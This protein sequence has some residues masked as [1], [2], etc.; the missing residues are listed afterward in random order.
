MTD[1][2][3]AFCGFVFASRF[4]YPLSC[5][6]KRRTMRL[7]ESR[8][9]SG[10]LRDRKVCATWSTAVLTDPSASLWMW[11][12]EYVA[13]RTACAKAQMM[14]VLWD[15]SGM[16]VRNWSSGRSI[17]CKNLIH[18]FQLRCRSSFVACV[19]PSAL[20]FSLAASRSTSLL[21]AEWEQCGSVEAA[22]G[23]FCEIQGRLVRGV[24]D[25]DHARGCLPVRCPSRETTGSKGMLCV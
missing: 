14:V 23:G 20:A 5:C 6:D 12:G 13:S 25:G 18:L 2:G 22:V 3:R 11:A 17:S 7:S 8:R 9:G 24:R 21:L 16:E 1:R 19:D 4:L 15:W 10:W